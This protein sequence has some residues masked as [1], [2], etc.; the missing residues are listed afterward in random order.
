MKRVYIALALLVL[1][2]AFSLFSF[3]T[4]TKE[5]KA[6]LTSCREIEKL[7]EREDYETIS[8]KG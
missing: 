1:C 4:I 8:A 5:S 2:C 6:M 3:F 7:L